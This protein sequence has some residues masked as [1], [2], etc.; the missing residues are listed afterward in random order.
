MSEFNES[1]KRAME[2]YQMEANEEMSFT[3][4]FDSAKFMTAL[5]I[6][7]LEEDSFENHQYRF[8]T[9]INLIVKQKDEINELYN[10]KKEHSIMK[11]LIVDNGLW[12]KLLNDDEFITYLRED[13]TGKDLIDETK[14][15]KCGE[16]KPAYCEDCMQKVIAENAALQKER[17]DIYDDYQDIGKEKCMNEIAVGEKVKQIKKIAEEI[18]DMV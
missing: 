11:R 16:G 17:D 7:A 13:Y 4:D 15:L 12:E 10:M 3:C 14:C 2:Y 8:K 5:G 1:E 18:W 9:L 6:K